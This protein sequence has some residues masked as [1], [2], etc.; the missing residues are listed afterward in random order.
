[1]VEVKFGRS[2]LSVKVVGEADL[3]PMRRSIAIDES[4]QS[5]SQADDVSMLASAALG[6]S[7]RAHD[8]V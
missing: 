7:G 6:S 1:M 3:G 5:E 2:W 8:V 4:S